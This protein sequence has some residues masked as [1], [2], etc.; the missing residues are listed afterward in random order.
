MGLRTQRY[1][2]TATRRRGASHGPG[3]PLPTTAKAETHARYRTAP[4]A[5]TTTAYQATGVG[6]PPPL[7]LSIH[8]GTRTPPAPGTTTLKRTFRSARLTSARSPLS[9][10]GASDR[11]RCGLSTAA[12]ADR[13]CRRPWLA[14]TPPDR[15]PPRVPPTPPHGQTPN[16]DREVPLPC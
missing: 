3:V 1:G 10:L 16:V 4:A 13:P 12:A 11:G 6:V 7:L 15:G 8:Q 9:F 14:T 5:I 2:P